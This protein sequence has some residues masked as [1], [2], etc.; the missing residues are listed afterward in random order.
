MHI[1]ETIKQL[2]KQSGYT[3]IE[4]GEIIGIT[5]TTLSHI[6]SGKAIPHKSTLKLI[7]SQFKIPE[8]VLFILS[9]ER[10][11]APEVNKEIFDLLY[12]TVK[13]L[14]CRIFFEKVS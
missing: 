6:E 2:R 4:F 3:Q 12:P 14:I 10:E 5:Q 11:S 9:L 7:C 1:G 8:Q 13:T